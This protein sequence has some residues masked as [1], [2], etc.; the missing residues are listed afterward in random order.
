MSKVISSFLVGLGFDYDKK[1][2]QE[3]E[4]GIGSIK[5]KALQLGTV[6]AGGFGL[7]SL[8]A[9]F[10][11]SRDMIGKFSETFGLIPNEVLALGNALTTQGGSL[12]GFMSQVENI[13]RV[14]ARLLVGDTS[15][16]APA[17]KAGIDPNTIVQAENA[18]EAYLSLANAFAGMTTQQR[19]NAAEALGLDEASIR[20]LSQGRS[21]VELLVQ[22]MMQ[23]RSV[24]DESTAAAA[25]FT[26][27]WTIL[28]QN[29]GSAT[30][31]MSAEILPFVND[32]IEKINEWTEANKNLVNS[33][34]LVF[35]GFATVAASSGTLGTL[36]KMARFIPMIGTGLASVA[37]GA[38]S[39]TAVSAAALGGYAVGSA[40]EEKL[41]SDYKIDLGRSIAHT[42][43]S[44]G[45]EEA[46]AALDAE[47]Q[48]GGY[49]DTFQKQVDAGYFGDRYA[50]TV[51]TEPKG[52]LS[53]V[54][55]AE[56]RR[57]A[58]SG[59]SAPSRQDINIT[60]E[61]DGEAVGRKIVTVVDG[62]AQTAIDDLSS[63]VGG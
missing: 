10:A 45:N 36:A 27:E 63:N 1:G 58:T 19:I 53:S 30:D 42:L 21:D 59:Q 62:M 43:A 13:E 37:A 31:S 54:N 34:A 55:F 9:D 57:A 33:N 11:S 28:K 4:S 35:A 48:A 38:S 46:Q 49:T 39:V 40:I 61:M 7:K 3:I 24:T 2:A 60:V 32:V 29:V 12:A 8:T 50:P 44:F 22:R 14:R 51:V 20:L 47:A 25:R 6:V 15:F 41:P 17:A 56:Q 16:F 52:N 23:V 5:S 26:K 18:T